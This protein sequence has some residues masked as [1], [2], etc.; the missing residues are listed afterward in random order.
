MKPMENWFTS[1]FTC[2]GY[3]HCWLV[4]FIYENGIAK[5]HMIKNAQ[6]SEDLQI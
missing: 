6:R 2:L 5:W 1:A 3:Y 4:Q